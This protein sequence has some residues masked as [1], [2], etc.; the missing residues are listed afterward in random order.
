MNFFEKRANII[1][2]FLLVIMFIMGIFS[3][4]G[5]SGTT[6]EVAHIPAGYSYLKYLDYRLNPEHPPLQK[7]ISAVPL[8]FL[9]LNFP[10]DIPA[11]TEDVNGQW[12]AG[13]KFLYHYGNNADQMLF[14]SRLP[15]LLYAIILGLYVFLWT[16]ELFGK[17][18]AL[19]ALLLFSF[20]PNILAHSRLVTTDLGVTASFFITLFYFYKFLKKPSWKYLAYSG[21][22]FG[23]AQL[24]KFSNIFLVIYMGLL[25]IL[26]LFLL[27]KKI[28]LFKLPLLH[29]IKNNWLQRTTTLIVSLVLIFIIGFILVG[30]VYTVFTFNMPHDVQYKLIEGSFAGE[31]AFRVHTRNILHAMQDNFITK[32]LSQYLLGLV[33]VFARIQGGN[34]TYFWGETTDQSWWYYYPL[35]FL[36]KTPLSTLLLFFLTWPLLLVDFVKKHQAQKIKA[37]KS[38]LALFYGKL[39]ATGWKFLPEIIMI[40]VT[41]AFF[42]I[43]INSNLNIGLRHVLP[44]Y[45]FMFMLIAKYVIKFFTDHKTKIE[46]LRFAKYSVLIIIIF[47]YLATSLISYPSYLAYFNE[48]IGRHNAYKYTVDSNLDWGQDLKRLT[49]Y[50]EDKNIKHIK[51]DYFGGSV[52]EYYL[53]DKQE[54][55]RSNMG[56]TTGWIAVSATYYQNSKYYSRT[57]GE[58]DYSWLEKYEPEA[59]IGGSILVYNVPGK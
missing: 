56:E 49:K 41:A 2:V 45:P 8:L 48:F 30:A 17:K 37:A 3:I 58:K 32:P 20:S 10:D 39:T 16:K 44:V 14:W 5:D 9:N 46:N 43:G 18:T 23:I 7:A 42:A 55:W 47:Y 15:I 36:I 22:A 11:W 51:V 40:S 54:T 27:R 38:K 53:G 26:A 12:E 29:K 52:P 13:W 50:V 34:T 57:M 24:V 19:F 6:D 28:F 35:S 31:E 33:M 25:V 59:I 4:R 21:I 1:A